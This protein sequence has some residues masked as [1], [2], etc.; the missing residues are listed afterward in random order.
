MGTF[1][2]VSQLTGSMWIKVV[3]GALAILIALFGLRLA[4]KNNSKLDR[5]IWIGFL[6]IGIVML[7][8]GAI[9]LI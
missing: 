4:K 8:Y 3:C 9:N 5:V 6:I 1:V 2:M 7:G